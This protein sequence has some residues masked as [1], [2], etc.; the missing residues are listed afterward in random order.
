MA[1][2]MTID[3]RRYDLLVQV[4]LNAADYLKAKFGLDRRDALTNIR[5]A[6]LSGVPIQGAMRDRLLMA[7]LLVRRLSGG[8]MEYELHLYVCS[9]EGNIVRVRLTVPYEDDWA[10]A[11][12]G[13]REKML[14][15]HVNE[16]MVGLY[17]LG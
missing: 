17:Q 7:D 15:E 13:F 11:P 1:Q 2:N 8:R 4:S 12:E 6:F 9:L 10:F 3:V 16:L 5:K 14:R